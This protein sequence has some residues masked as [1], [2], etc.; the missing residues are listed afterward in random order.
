M[1]CRLKNRICEAQ[2]FLESPFKENVRL[3][4]VEN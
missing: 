3:L 1:L 2:R 4:L